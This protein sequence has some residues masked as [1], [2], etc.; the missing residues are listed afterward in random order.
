MLQGFSNFSVEIIND[1]AIKK[2][3]NSLVEFK[4]LKKQ[5]TKQ[6]E[7]VKNIKNIDTP[8]ILQVN[9]YEFFF[10]M[11]YMK[12]TQN[13]L[14][15]LTNNNYNTDL[16]FIDILKD[17][18]ETHIRNAKYE[19]IYDVFKSKVD[20]T[21]NNC[22][23]N[24][25]VDE[26]LFFDI[27]TK[28]YNYLETFNK[29][30]IIPLSYCHGDLSLSNILIDSNNKKLYFIDFLDNFTNTILQDIVKLRQDTHLKLI[31]P[32]NDFTNEIVYNKLEE[33]DLVFDNFFKQYD[34]YKYYNL[35]Q[36]LNVLRII[37][38]S[39]DESFIKILLSKIVELLK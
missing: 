30:L 1:S 36:I 38:Y 27:E 39:K 17:Y 13:F 25:L 10:M 28:Y 34:F 12:K 21:I 29:K 37:P 2:S 32:M 35:F 20:D 3:A 7:F 19:N 23:K 5:C 15:Y 33:I 26:Q 31:L 9:D 11:K 18:F 14:L 4:R 8:Q 24:K 16:F 22:K 6:S